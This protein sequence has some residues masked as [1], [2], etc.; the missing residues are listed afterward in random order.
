MTTNSTS[1]SF[2]RIEVKKGCYISFIVQKALYF[3]NQ[4]IFILFT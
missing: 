1:I 4:K 2:N 3:I